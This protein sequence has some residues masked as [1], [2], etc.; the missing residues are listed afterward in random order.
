MLFRTLLLVFFIGLSVCARAKDFQPFAGPQPL[1]VLVE[2]DPLAPVVGAETPHI[3]IYENGDVIYAR[4]GSGKRGTTYFYAK[5]SYEALSAITAKLETVT[6]LPEIKPVYSVSESP[7][8]GS[9]LFYFHV[10]GRETVISVHGLN[11]QG[12]KAAHSGNLPAAIR[13]LYDYLWTLDF[14]EARRWHPVYV[15]AMVWPDDE[16]PGKSLP[17]PKSWPDLGSDR[18]ITRGN[19][20]SI[21]LDSSMQGD[22]EKFVSFANP[23]D[24]VEIDGRKWSLAWRPVFPSDP[25]WRKAFADVK[26]N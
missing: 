12:E 13:E 26:G 22:L 2:E 8:D 25:V 20:F 14:Q 7:D 21:F 19:G 16:A 18:A 1:A 24:A 11:R 5:L 3:A 6:D 23:D 15:E 17:W 10:D 4:E 9:A